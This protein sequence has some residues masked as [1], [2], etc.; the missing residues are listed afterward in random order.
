MY[1]P[2]YQGIEIKCTQ[3]YSGYPINL[4][5]LAFDGPALYQMNEILNKYGKQDVIYR[6][7]KI[8]MATLSTL[9]KVLVNNKYY[10][11]LDVS[12]EEEK[13]YLEIYDK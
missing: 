6:D 13:L 9:D 3:R 4:F 1:F 8:L 10:F 7:K 12:V 5:S 2:D 11:K